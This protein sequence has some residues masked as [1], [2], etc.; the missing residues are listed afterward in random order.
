MSHS[1]PRL[2]LTTSTSSHPSQ[3]VSTSP[4]THF[5][6]AMFHGRVA[7]QHKSHLSQEKTQREEL[8]CQVENDTVEGPVVKSMSVPSLEKENDRLTA[9]LCTF[10][11]TDRGKCEVRLPSSRVHRH[12]EF[13]LGCACMERATEDRESLM[14][15]FSKDRWLVARDK[16][17][18]DAQHRWI[19]S[20]LVNEVITS[21]V[22]ALVVESD[23]RRSSIRRRRSLI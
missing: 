21:D 12:L 18:E 2:T 22:Q 1:L 20:K 5:C 16:E 19:G 13:H 14:C 9:G 8:Q 3:L 4:S 10:R 6:L 23:Q 7:D 11:V 17:C 15:R